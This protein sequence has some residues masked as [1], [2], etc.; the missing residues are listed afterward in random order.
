M[1]TN[2]K[3]E[4]ILAKIENMHIVLMNKY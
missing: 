3:K 4:G 1:K 2:D